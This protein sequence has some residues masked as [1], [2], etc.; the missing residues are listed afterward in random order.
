MPRKYRKKTNKRRRR[1]KKPRR[2]SLGGFPRTKMVRLR[3]VQQIRLNATPTAPAVVAFRANSL[4]DPYVSGVGH[5]PAN[6]DRLSAIY[7]NFTVL[8]SRIRCTNINPETVAISGIQGVLLAADPNAIAEIYLATGITSTGADSVMEQSL[9]GNKL[10]SY[11]TRTGA[12][13]TP[14]VIKNY[15]SAKKFFHRTASAV[16]S[17]GNCSHTALANPEMEAFFLVYALPIQNTDPGNLTVL[18]E[19]EYIA[20]CTNPEWDVP[21]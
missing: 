7:Q 12:Q 4:Y 20:M 18:C 9:Q 16:I 10:Q 2:I 8:G 13:V 3:Y 17:S 5:Q 6:F 21:S 15:F 1:R 11:G 14:L 19:I